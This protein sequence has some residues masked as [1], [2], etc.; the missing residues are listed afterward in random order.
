MIYDDHRIDD[1][2]GVLNTIEDLASVTL[3]GGTGLS[4]S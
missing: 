1:E 4:T 2:A 3:H